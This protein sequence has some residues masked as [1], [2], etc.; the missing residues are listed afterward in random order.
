M[1]DVTTLIQFLVN[2]LAM[3]TVY[4]L[5]ALS[6]ALLYNAVGIL[7]FAVGEFVMVPAFIL[8]ILLTGGHL[9]FGLACVVTLA[10]M[11]VFGI[12]FHRGVYHPLR[13]RTSFIS[14]IVSTIGASLFLKNTALL[15][16]GADPRVTP[17]VFHRSS[18]GLF[19]VFV[20]SQYLVILGTLLVLV[21]F[22]YL[23]F[24]KT[25]LG[26][27]M[28][29][30]AQDR[31]M[32]RLVGIRVDLIILLTFIYAAVLGGIGGILLAPI[33]YVSS[34]MGFL[35]AVKG[36]SSSI[37]GGLGSIPGAIVGGLFIGIVEL[38][39]AAFVSATYKD[40]FAFII[41]IAVLLFR[42][43]GFFGE[44]VAEKV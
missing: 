8:S 42:P 19:G 35:I 23:L 31:D 33:F 2:G 40:V 43:R 30:T 21:V 13:S 29:A 32:A 20:A 5:V 27:Q 7:N 36:F 18:V 17:P 1:P 38:F 10:A 25:L 16:F 4:A 6:F 39:G 28:R 14:V 41:L 24:E 15:V 44:K 9:S 12:I 22:Q 26:K 37:V 3:G 11:V 34:T